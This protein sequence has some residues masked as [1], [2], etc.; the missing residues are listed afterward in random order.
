LGQMSKTSPRARTLSF[1]RGGVHPPQH[2]ERTRNLPIAA[3]PVPEVLV[4]PMLQHIGAAARP[5]VKKRD[6][7]RKGQVIG[8]AQG[9]ISANVHSPV[10][11]KVRA[12]ERAIHNVTGRKVPAVIIENDGDE[13]WAPGCNEAQKVNGMDARRMVEMVQEAGVVGLGGAAFPAHVKLSPPAHTPISDVFING[14]ECEPFVTCDHRL[15]LERTR[16][17]MEALR[18]IMHIL[19]APDGHIGIEE[20]KPDAIEA[21]RQALDSDE[22]ITVHS[23]KVKYPQGAE[24]Q[25]IKAVTGREMP[26]GGGLPADVGCLVHNVGTALAIRDA[27]MFRRPLIERVVTVTG[28]GVE[29]PGNFLVRIGTTVQ[30][31]LARQGIREGTRM[32][33][34]GGPMMGIAQ[35]ALE[36]PIIKGNNAV[37]L[38][39][40]GPFA[41]QRACIRCGRCVEHCPL[42]LVP[43]DLSIACENED[44]DAALK[45][46]ILE[47][48]ECGCC[49]YVCP[50]NRRIVHQ[51]KF[52]KAEIAKRKQTAGG[53]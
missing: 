2:K 10:S 13:T 45:A 50:A 32:V 27:V 7:V 40:A 34:L 6:R 41:P 26:D 33:I 31:M 15:M 22:R 3:F 48:K 43:S 30:E 25:L 11:G 49:A 46:S 35:G 51:I 4:V 12:I 37:L 21:F 53:R 24:Q 28:E 9:Y 52:G 19:D 5:I 16:E 23:L 47:C 39:G 29:R 18:L 38:L 8:E 20:N 1:S 44:W 17:I 36:S 14:A 42:G